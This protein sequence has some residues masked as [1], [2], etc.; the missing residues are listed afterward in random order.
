MVEYFLPEAQFCKGVP[1]N[2]TTFNDLRAASGPVVVPLPNNS[3]EFVAWIFPNNLRFPCAGQVAKWIFRVPT[4]INGAEST[5]PQWTIFHENTGT[6]RNND[7]SIRSR[8]GSL[9]E[10]SNLEGDIFQYTLNTPV[11]VEE[12]D[13]LGITYNM[14]EGL[15][16]LFINKFPSPLSYWSNR[17]LTSLF[18]L[19]FTALT[20]A[21][22]RLVP[23]VIPVMGMYYKYHNIKFGIVQFLSKQSPVPL[24]RST[25]KALRLVC[26]FAPHYFYIVFCSE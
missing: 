11:A 15:Q 21:D 2:F 1:D 23:L 9:G 12:G 25:N 18:D 20:T 24:T 6:P 26:T 5:V 22:D 19:R 4:P 10:L 8:S 13:I 17:P 7:Y 14:S 3:L 16:V